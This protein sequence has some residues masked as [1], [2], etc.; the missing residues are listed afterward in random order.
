MEHFDI[1][2]DCFD[3]LNLPQQQLSLSKLNF[4]DLFSL[5]NL[6]KLKKEK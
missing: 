3:G 2:L 1:K 4:S 5:L 6:K